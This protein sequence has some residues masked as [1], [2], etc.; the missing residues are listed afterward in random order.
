MPVLL[1]NGV[2]HYYEI[3]GRGT[4]LVFIH[5]GFVDSRMWEPQVKHFSERYQVLRYD[6]R[7]HGRTGGTKWDRYTIDL[8]ADDLKGLLET[9]GLEPFIMCGL[10]LGGMIAQSFAVRYTGS[11]LALILA[12]TAVSVRLTL[13]DKFQRYILAPKWSMLA[14]L[15]WMTV[16][17]FVEFSFKL[18]RWTRSTGWFGQD[19][20]TAEYVRAAM[21]NIPTVEYLKIYDAI[22]GFDLLNLAAISVPTLVLNGQ[23]ESKAVYRHTDEMIKLIPN[24]LARI[25]PDAGHT[26]NMENPAAFNSEIDHFLSQHELT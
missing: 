12:D 2:E 11:L 21:L 22:Y 3:T 18:A 10:S 5:G 15:R 16:P 24:A 26:S 1:T 6:L 9:L 19:R 25:I 13:G 14:I 4:P 7:G 23:H 8:F 20:D 17:R